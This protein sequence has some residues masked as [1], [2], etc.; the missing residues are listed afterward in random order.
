VAWEPRLAE[1]ARLHSR[2]LA[3]TGRL[4]H[5]GRHGSSLGERVRA[6]GYQPRAWAENVA[7]GQRTAAAVIDAWLESPGHCANIMNP[8]YT[9]VGAAAVRGE[10]GRLYW[11]LVLAT[12]AS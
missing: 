11:T 3:E 2:Y 8:A 12:P 1:A 4:G 9:D 7:L 10:D 6:A 5:T